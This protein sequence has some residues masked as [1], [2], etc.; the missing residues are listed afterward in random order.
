MKRARRL[1]NSMSADFAILSE[2]TLHDRYLRVESRLVRYPDGREVAF[3]IVGHPKNEHH[4]VVVFVYFTA[5]R[6]AVLLREFAQAALPQR[7]SLA[8]LPT[9]G[10]DP[11]KHANRAE[12][13][14]AELSEEAQLRG[15]EWVCLLPPDHPGVLEAKWCRN[16]FTPFLCI[17]PEPDPAHGALDAEEH[18]TAQEVPLQ[19]VLSAMHG[20]DMLLPAVHTCS[21]ALAWL[22]QHRR[23]VDS[24]LALPGGCEG[25]RGRGFTVR[26]LSRASDASLYGRCLGLRASLLWPRESPPPSAADYD[27]ADGE[28]TFF[29]AV[30]CTGQGGEEE[31]EL[32]G[33]AMLHDGR[34]RQV[35]A[36]PAAR[37]QG[38]GAALVS[39]AA[40]A[41][42]AEGRDEL[43]VG[44][45]AT[46]ETFY[47]RC[48][49][50]P[51]SEPYES[52]GMSC[53]RLRL[54]LAQ[55]GA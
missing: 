46:S 39:A 11:R 47:S 35:V 26:R 40:E 9:G 48:G 38:V 14:R 5:R 13:A 22:R 55:A 53:R 50:E 45:W 49:F 6:S 37:G 30:R 1:G 18:L 31:A 19:A 27:T 43:S 33:T 44:A 29:A 34:L 51:D 54:R 21:C 16:R 3:D 42:R 4:F 41:A 7:G 8:N 20:G 2:S 52:N 23:V 10:F 15:G 12:A 28:A 32:L 24:P 36:V 25:G 17:D